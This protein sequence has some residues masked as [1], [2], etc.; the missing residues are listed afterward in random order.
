MKVKIKARTENILTQK[1]VFTR[2]IDSYL[3]AVN[4]YRVL[5][6]NINITFGSAY[7]VACNSHSLNYRVRVALKYRAVH[8]RAGVA[9]VRITY[10][11]FLRSLIRR[12][13]SPLSARGE[14]AAASAAKARI[15]N[16]LNN[17]LRSHFGQNLT[18]S[19]VA[20]H[21]YV[22]V[23]I[24]GVDNAAVTKNNAIL[25]FIESGVAKG[26]IALDFIS[27]VAGIVINQALNNT[28]F[29][30]V[31]LN[32]FLNVL[33]GYSAVKSTVRINDNNRSQSAETETACLYEL[34]LVRKSAA[35][36]ILSK[37]LLNIVASRRG[38][39]GTA[40]DQHMCTNH[41][42]TSKFLLMSGYR[43]FVYDVTVFK[44]LL[45]YARRLF[46]SHFNIGY[47]F[48]ARLE[49]LYNRL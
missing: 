39:A 8:K 4:G 17:V 16:A 22:F 6:T 7:C 23:N 37:R 9:L 30:Q 35:F 2:L 20:V 41:F 48:L 36:N 34:Y 40:A 13:Q 19:G 46:G 25:R 33:W 27:Y 14:A 10:N 43:I 44:M 24:F 15:G 28:A 45:N 42:F 32:Y 3:Q 11:I 29:K 26:N 31:L 12:A 5:C 18:E 21:S 1:P 49:D 47:L 38:T